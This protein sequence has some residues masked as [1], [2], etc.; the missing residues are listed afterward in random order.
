MSTD[1]PR[2]P[3]DVPGIDADPLIFFGG[4]GWRSVRFEV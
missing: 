1:H 4:W 2:L 3:E